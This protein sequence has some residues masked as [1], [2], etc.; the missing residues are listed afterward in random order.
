MVPSTWLSIVFFILCIAPGLL[1]DLLAERRRAGVSESAFRE[2]SRVVLASI[3]FTAVGLLVIGSIRAITPS[4]MPDPRQLFGHSNTYAQNH[5]RLVLSALVLELAVACLIAVGVHMLLAGRKDGPPLRSI[6]SWQRVFRVECP[7]DRVAYIRVRTKDGTVHTGH[8]GYWTADLDQ[9]E[10]E[11]VLVP[12]LWS[13]TG[14]GCLAPV[15]AEWQRLV[16]PAAEIVSMHVEYRPRPVD[17]PK[18]S[19]G[20]SLRRRR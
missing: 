9:A 18:V 14:S 8:V 16:L 20:R 4:L 2:A 15:P 6:S 13:K 19:T 10:R 12:P 17:W 11:I 3:A 5:Y 1:F 7:I